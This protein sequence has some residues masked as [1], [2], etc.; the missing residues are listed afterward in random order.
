MKSRTK[1][2]PIVY[3]YPFV[4]LMKR[5]Y[6]RCHMRY[7]AATCLFKLARVKDFDRGLSPHFENIATMLMDSSAT[8]RHKLLVKL[9]EILP[10]QRLLP[11]WNMILAMTAHDPEPENVALVSCL[12]PH[13][14]VKLIIRRNRSWLIIFELVR[15]CRK[16][17]SS[18][19]SSCLWRG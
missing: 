17:I 19:G 9:G 13:P 6:A 7:R 18:R 5:C 11:R 16:T 15:P 8:V 1:G 14:R 12:I 10:T 3:L 2:K 4:V